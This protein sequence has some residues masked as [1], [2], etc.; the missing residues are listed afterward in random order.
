MSSLTQWLAVLTLRPDLRDLTVWGNA[1][2]AK[3]SEHLAELQ[4]L[5]ADGTVVLAGRTDEVDATGRLAEEATGIIVFR[6]PTREAAE[7]LIGGDAAIK[8][9]IM[10]A[11]VRLFNVAALGRRTRARADNLTCV[12]TCVRKDTPPPT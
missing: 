4:R 8:A 12:L 2:T 6:A 5:A 3:I 10:H 1:E 7:A 9:G 11:R